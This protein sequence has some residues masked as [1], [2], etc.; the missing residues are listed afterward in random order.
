[1]NVDDIKTLYAYNRWANERLFSAL[2]IMSDHQFTE[3]VPSSFP[4]IRET[5][6]H[7]LFA[8]WLWLKRWQGRSPR[9]TLADPDV[10][11]AT[12]D[13]LSPGGMPAMKELATLEA[14]KAFADSIERERQEFLAGLSED[15][16]HA[17]LR[18]SDMSGTLY[19]EPLVQLMQHLV[20][21]GTYH[22]GQV[23][24]MQRQIGVQTVA[25]DMLYFFRERGRFRE[26]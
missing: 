5:L 18:F 19:A 16:L 20:N 13:T 4:S 9:S 11:P 23:I 26:P 8:E 10:S 6:F 2:E 1:M 24:T 14:L 17:R 12:W 22:R 21:H 3:A 7:I 15:A 25:L